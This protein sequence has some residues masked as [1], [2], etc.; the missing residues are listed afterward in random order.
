MNIV[1]PVNAN[2][3]NS[4]THFLTQKTH[5]MKKNL[6]AASSAFLFACL[7]LTACQQEDGVRPTAQPS[8]LEIREV[9]PCCVPSLP[10][11]DELVYTGTHGVTVVAHNDATTTYVTISRPAGVMTIRYANPG[12]CPTQTNGPTLCEGCSTYTV[13]F[14]NPAGWECGDVVNFSFYLNGLGGP[15]PNTLQTCVINYTLKDV[16]GCETSMTSE[17]T[18]DEDAAECGRTVTYTFT[19]AEDGYVEIQGGLTNNTEICSMSATGGL[20]GVLRDSPNQANVTTWTGDVVACETYTITINWTR[21]ASPGGDVDP[22]AT[23][24]WTAVL[25]GVE[26]AAVPEQSCE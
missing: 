2:T 5:F 20:T 17:L 21:F 7:F 22:E 3:A 11:A 23:G 10:S 6:F 15:P 14:P 8:A 26:V 16:C 19:P 25:N 9:D 12:L 4:F 24:E 1:N 13:S 18:C